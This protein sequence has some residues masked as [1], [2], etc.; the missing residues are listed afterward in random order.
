MANRTKLTAKKRERFIEVLSESANVTLAAQAIGMARAYMYEV[1]EQDPAFA[2]LWDDAL[3]MAADAM[4]QEAWRR[5]MQGTDK[6]VFYQG[7]ECGHIKEYS[8][9]LLMFRLKAIRPE[10]YRDNQVHFNIDFTKLT[11]EQL[12][13]LARGEHPAAVLGN[14]R[15]SGNIQATASPTVH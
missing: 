7:V 6:P 14:R 8:D 3:Q 15:G 11:D 10:Q 4:E 5:A 2:A 12:E 9:T 1:R 13:R